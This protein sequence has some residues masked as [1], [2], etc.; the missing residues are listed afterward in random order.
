MTDDFQKLLVKYSQEIVNPSEETSLHK[1]IQKENIEE[2]IN[3][4]N[5]QIIKETS[6]QK[7]KLRD[8]L[9]KTVR[10]FIWVQLIFFNIIVGVIV[11]AVT[12]SLPYFKVVDNDLATLLFDFLKYYIGATIVEL[13]GMLVFV[14]HYAFSDS[15]GST[16]KIKDLIAKK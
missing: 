8:R 10:N 14:L 12:I 13:L 6:E 2:K 15:S 3:N 11:A 1:I 5:L 4:Y 7:I 9:T 16:N